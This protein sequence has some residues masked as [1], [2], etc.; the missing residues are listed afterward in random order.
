MQK[1]YLEKID[2]VFG[3]H[4]LARIPKFERDITGLAMIERMAKVMFGS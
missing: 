2:Q 1:T 3:A 4:T